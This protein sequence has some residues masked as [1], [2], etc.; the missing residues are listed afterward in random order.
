MEAEWE[1]L[2][3]Q[4]EQHEL[5]IHPATTQKHIH[6]L[7]FHHAASLRL[8]SVQQHISHVFVCLF[9]VYKE[10]WLHP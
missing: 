10:M 5:Y 4:Q 7:V 1:R 3:L 9:T 8:L 2:Q 6:T